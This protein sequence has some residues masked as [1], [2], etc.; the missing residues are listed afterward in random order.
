MRSFSRNMNM[1]SSAKKWRNVSVWE[2]RVE[3][4]IV[5]RDGVKIPYYFT[6]MII[7]YEGRI[8]SWVWV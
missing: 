3:A 8:A 2:D 6:G 7:N 1:R 5:T 4:N